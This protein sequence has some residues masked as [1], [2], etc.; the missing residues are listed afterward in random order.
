MSASTASAAAP[1][2][3]AVPMLALLM[4]ASVAVALI[5]FVRD[6]WL[7][8]PLDDALLSAGMIGV[9]LYLALVGG[10][11]A[12]QRI[13]DAA[14][15]ADP[16]AAATAKTGDARKEEKREEKTPAAAAVPEKDLVAA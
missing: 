11:L 16:K 12:V 1:D 9:V 6:L 3:P 14:P 2:T 4:Q 8:A 13:L 7:L 10:Y 15:K 5:V